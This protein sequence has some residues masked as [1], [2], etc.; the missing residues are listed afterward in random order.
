[1]EEEEEA[2]E[3]EVET[4]AAVPIEARLRSQVPKLHASSVARRIIRH[5]NAI[6]RRA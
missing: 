4:A 5:W 1:M 2:I 3:E 6:L